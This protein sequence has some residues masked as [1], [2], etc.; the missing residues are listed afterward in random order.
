ML[1]YDL[2][3]RAELLIRLGRGAEADPLL[4]E[5]EAGAGNGIEAF[6]ERE[7]RARALK[8]L[9]AVIDARFTD[10]ARIA[11]DVVRKEPSSEG[12]SDRTG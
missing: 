9:R 2:T 10:A 11:G 8:A 12:T 3:N 6:N 7:R 5:L 4:A 1:A